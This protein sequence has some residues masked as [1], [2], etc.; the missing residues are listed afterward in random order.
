MISVTTRDNICYVNLDRN[1][2]SE[3]YRVSPEVAV[4][5]LVNS[6]TE[7]DGVESVQISVDGQPDAVFME[8]LSLS[9]SFKRNEALILGAGTFG[10]EE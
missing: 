1:F 4:Y 9:G 2:Q 5:S 8:S 10:Q 3:P 7:L 6:L